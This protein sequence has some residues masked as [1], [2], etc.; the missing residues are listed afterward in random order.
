MGGAGGGASDK[1]GLEGKGNRFV[2]TFSDVFLPVPFLASPFD[3]HRTKFCLRSNFSMGGP[4]G[5]DRTAFLGDFFSGCI[6]LRIN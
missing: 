1:M 5:R 4:L 6:V 3:L 2:M